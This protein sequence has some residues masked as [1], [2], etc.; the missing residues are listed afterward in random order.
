MSDQLK[1]FLEESKMQ[2]SWYNIYA[3]LTN[4]MDPPLHNGNLK[5][6]VPD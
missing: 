1:Y 6:I 5:H 3:D 4:P 2:K